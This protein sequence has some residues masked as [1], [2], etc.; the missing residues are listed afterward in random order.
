MLRKLNQF[1]VSHPM[2]HKSNVD[3]VILQF[4]LSLLQYNLYVL[5]HIQLCL[6][7]K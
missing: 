2:G 6:G 5:V 3:I 4:N 7:I 1:I